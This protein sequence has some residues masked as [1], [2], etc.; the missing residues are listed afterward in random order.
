MISKT[1]ERQGWWARGTRRAVML[2]AQVSDA[3]SLQSFREKRQTINREPFF[4]H[5]IHGIFEPC[6]HI[7]TECQLS[8]LEFM[9]IIHKEC[10][11]ILPKQQ[12]LQETVQLFFLGATP[13]M[14]T[15]T[16]Q[17]FSSV[18]ISAL[19]GLDFT[20]KWQN[21]VRYNFIF[22]PDGVFQGRFCSVLTHLS[23]EKLV[24]SLH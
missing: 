10:V 1:C 5:E 21:C 15:Q 19:Q 22:I 8:M 2:W 24:T 6:L 4:L 13:T 16:V 17:G 3:N 9:F 23:T 11:W 14:E 12:R 20:T 18:S 7:R